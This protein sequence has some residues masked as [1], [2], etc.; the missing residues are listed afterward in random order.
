MRGGEKQVMSSGVPLIIFG[1][2]SCTLI[3]LDLELD[4]SKRDGER[5][6]DQPLLK[7]GLTLIQALGCYPGQL[8]WIQATLDQVCVALM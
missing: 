3:K 4:G 1:L 7:A 8:I 6:T 5:E 2:P